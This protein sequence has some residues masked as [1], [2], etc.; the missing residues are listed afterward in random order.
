MKIKA[1]DLKPGDKI[2]LPG[3]LTWTGN[4][5]T[6]INPLPTG[7]IEIFWGKETEY[8]TSNGMATFLPDTELEVAE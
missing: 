1:K 4:I 8:T 6:F 7:D 5:I 2:H 3:Y